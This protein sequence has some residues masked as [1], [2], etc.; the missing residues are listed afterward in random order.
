MFKF[1]R[2]SLKHRQHESQ[3]SATNEVD[4][5]NVLIVV[6]WD[7]EYGGVAS[8]VGN[9][10]KYHQSQGHR[11]IFLHPGETNFLKEKTTKWG[12][13][14]FTLKL[15]KPFH[16]DH[17]VRS[18]LAFIGFLPVT[19]IQL[20]YLIRRYQISI[21]NIHYPLDSFICFAICRWLL[22][23]KLV[24]SVHGADLFP[25]GQRLTKY[26]YAL[27]FLLFSANAIVAPSQ[28]FLNDV[29]SLFPKLTTKKATFIHNGVDINKIR[30]IN[31]KQT[32]SSHR[33]ILCVAANNPKKA[34][35]VLIRAFASLRDKD[36]ML[37]LIIV[38][39][40]PLRKQY[41]ELSKS[42]ALQDRIEFAGSKGPAEV[43]MLINGCEI[44]VLPSRSEPFGIV[45]I[46]AM[47]CERPVVATAVGGIPEI[48]ENGRSGILVEPDN[49][50]A[51]A[52]ALLTLLK[53][54][55]LQ[56]TLGKNGYTRVVECFRY[57]DTGAKYKSLF[58]DLLNGA[59][60]SVV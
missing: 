31:K 55:K 60:K 8:V 25:A 23:C 2:A 41:E 37:K 12:F 11:V 42:L 16:L 56:R 43:S 1:C 26:S 21:V 54:Y 3:Q 53:N 51:L 34:I 29:R 47:A 48:I 58:S 32:F 46:E 14:G 35:D 57:E 36:E 45:I 27:K 59:R 24:I 28:A 44:F 49:P 22:L 15:R 13:R 50:E 5:M 10:G 17:P 52:H 6:P 7:Q 30:Q 4:K 9:L 38:G 40:G 18:I 39:D 33:Y 20:I 19:V